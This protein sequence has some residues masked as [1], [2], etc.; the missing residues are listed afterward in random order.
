MR[1]IILGLAVSLDGFIE[2][3]NGEYDWCFTDQDYG[4][5]DFFKRIDAIFMGRKSYEESKK[6]EGQNPWQ[7]IKTYIFSNTLSE[8]GA[9]EVIIKGDVTK[10]VDAIRNQSGKDIWL[11]GGAALTTSFINANLI[12]EY[13]L[14]IHPILLGSGK[15]LF[16]NISGRRNLKLIDHRI[17]SS[18]LASLVYRK[19]H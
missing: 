8:A 5:N 2:G 19:V 9:N 7:G 13:W 1:K 15:P 4:L 16:Q 18:G 6:Y 11:F 17:Y 3:P 14:S 12:D 10:E